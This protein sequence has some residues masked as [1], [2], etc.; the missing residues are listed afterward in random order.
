[1][2]LQQVKLGKT[3]TE[4]LPFYV[5]FGWNLY[6]TCKTNGCVPATVSHVDWRVQ[7]TQI[8]FCVTFT[9]LIE[10]VY[11]ADIQIWVDNG[12]EKSKQ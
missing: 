2:G 7:D 8:H 9:E 5:R 1:M 12:V 3:K 10:I 11:F 4:Y 6:P